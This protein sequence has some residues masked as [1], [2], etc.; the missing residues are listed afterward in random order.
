MNIKAEKNLY[1]EFG[2]HNLTLAVGEYDDELNFKV[3]EKDVLQTPGYKDGEIINIEA[4][5]NDL[6]K[7]LENIEKKNKFYF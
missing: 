4:S 5:S 3:L 6:K 1:I 2:E 7:A